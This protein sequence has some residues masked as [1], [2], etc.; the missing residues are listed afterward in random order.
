MFIAMLFIIYQNSVEEWIKKK[1]WYIYTM[2]YCSA[3]KKEEY[4]TLYDS[5][6]GPREHYA[7]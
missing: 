3:A 4:V 6:D 1:Q 5:K 7:N 2:E